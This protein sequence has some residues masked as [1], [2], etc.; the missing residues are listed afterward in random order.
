MSEKEKKRRVL[1]RKNREKW[2]FVQGLII[3]LIVLFM[4]SSIMKLFF[5]DSAM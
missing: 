3:A 1:Y 5:A 4:I 2:I